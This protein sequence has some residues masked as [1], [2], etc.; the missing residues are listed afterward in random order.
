MDDV[1]TVVPG[2]HP[3]DGHGFRLDRIGPAAELSH[4][5]YRA[6]SFDDGGNHGIGGHEVDQG[7]VEMFAFV[8]P[9]EFLRRAGFETEHSESQDSEPLFFDDADD[10]SDHPLADCVGLYDDQ[11][12]F[13]HDCLTFSAMASPRSEVD[14]GPP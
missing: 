11:S 8:I 3:P 14:A 2:E 12:A 6:R 13:F 5:F 10:F 7:F 1:V 4:F 9:V